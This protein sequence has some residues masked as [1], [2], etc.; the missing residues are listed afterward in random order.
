M[1]D[2]MPLLN[3]NDAKRG[4]SKRIL[5]ENSQVTGVRLIGETLAT[6]WLKE[7]MTNGHL[8]R[9]TSLGA[10]TLPAPPSSGAQIIVI[11]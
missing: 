10:C 9:I 11:V 2:D 5:I 1:T 7:V 6:D 3:Y 8:R 4:I